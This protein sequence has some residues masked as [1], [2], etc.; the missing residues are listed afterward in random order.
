[1]LREQAGAWQ[2][3]I[4]RIAFRPALTPSFPPPHTF[5][6][7]HCKRFV[8][9]LVKYPPVKHAPFSPQGHPLP[10]TLPPSTHQPADAACR[11]KLVLLRQAWTGARYKLGAY[12]RRP[13]PGNKRHAHLQQAAA[14]LGADE[15]LGLGGVPAAQALQQKAMKAEMSLFMAL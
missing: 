3:S 8:S 5:P 11:R 7:A 12:A 6:H 10:S 14:A 1:M 15:H 9:H 13:A 2:Q 4:I